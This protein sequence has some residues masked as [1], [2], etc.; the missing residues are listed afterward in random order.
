MLLTVTNNVV[1]MTANEYQ[2]KK[3]KNLFMLAVI[4]ALGI[5]LMMMP[6]FAY[7]AAGLTQAKNGLE[8]FLSE[9]QPMIRIVGI[10]A[11]IL[12]GIGY[13]MGMIDK[14]MFFKIVLGLIIVASAGDIVGF[15][16]SN[17]V[18]SP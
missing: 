16:Y 10:I 18:T 3:K 7:A 17:T 6:D 14:S 15:F 11:I 13:I 1:A 2:L 4:A 5:F 9:I 8:S 12:T